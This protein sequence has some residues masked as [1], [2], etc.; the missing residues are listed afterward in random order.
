[1]AKNKENS[2]KPIYIG[3]WIIILSFLPFCDKNISA[4]CWECCPEKWE[5]LLKKGNELKE[6]I[7]KEDTESLLE[8]FQDGYTQIW[9]GDSYMSK[10]ELREDFLK[11]DI[12]YGIF[13]NTELL[14]KIWKQK[15]NEEM[16]DTS[17][18]DKIKVAFKKKLLE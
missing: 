3:R 12:I 17:E 11:K 14:R 6:I 1:M 7:L 5:D 13:F 16:D 15:Y 18:L 10:E 9:S 2:F 8:L 4:Q